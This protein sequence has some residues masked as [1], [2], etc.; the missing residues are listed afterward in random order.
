MSTPALSPAA[1]T[2]LDRLYRAYNDRMV[3]LAYFRTGDYHTAEDLAQNA[4]IEVAKSIGRLHGED[5]AAWPW[6]AT[7]VR[8]CV[9]NHYALRSAGERVTD[10]TAP[11][12]ARSLPSAPSADLVTLTDPETDL[13][14]PVRQALDLLPQAQRS[15]LLARAEGRTWPA[16]GAYLGRSPWTVNENARRGAETLRPLLAAVVS[17]RHVIAA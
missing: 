5:S 2:R 10:W 16:V 3:R 1:A 14:A 13:S 17:R 8:R 11:R 15:A 9:A 6:L 4:W 12:D 7:I